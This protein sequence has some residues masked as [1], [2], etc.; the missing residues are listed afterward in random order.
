MKAITNH[1]DRLKRAREDYKGALADAE[2][3]RD[4]NDHDLESWAYE[5]AEEIRLFIKQLESGEYQS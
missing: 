2:F 5:Q 4:D 3:Y 1:L